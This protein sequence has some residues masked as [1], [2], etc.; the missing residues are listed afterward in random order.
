[1]NCEL[2]GKR[3]PL[4]QVNVAIPVDPFFEVNEP[5]EGLKFSALTQDFNVAENEE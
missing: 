3:K 1:M 5:D 4:L 2:F